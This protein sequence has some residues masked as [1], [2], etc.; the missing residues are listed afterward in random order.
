METPQFSEVTEYLVRAA[1]IAPPWRATQCQFDNMGKTVHIWI[2]RHPAVQTIRKRNWLGVMRTQTIADTTMRGPELRWRHLNCMDFT[3]IVH[4]TDVLDPRHHELPWL[5][6]VISPFTNKMA[7]QLFVCLAEGMDYT[8]ICNLLKISFTDLWK[9]KFALDSG[10]LKFDYKP[11]RKA[12]AETLSNAAGNGALPVQPSAQHM[13][14]SAVPDVSHPV[15]GHLMEGGADIQINT[16]GFQ[17][18]LT[19]LRQQVRVQQSDE[20]KLLKLR[21]LHRY[22]ERN[23]RS[24]ASELEQLRSLAASLETR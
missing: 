23:A 19:K 8:V 20:V 14:T 4:T 1:G 16:L 18:L 5:G 9:F 13:Q 10:A 12:L 2:S 21:E 7:R 15:W 22:V 6:E 11:M 24:L 3:C 17:L